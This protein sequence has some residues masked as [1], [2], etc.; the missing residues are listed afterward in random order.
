MTA[1]QL[2]I[3]GVFSPNEGEEGQ[4]VEFAVLEWK[5]LPQRDGPTASDELPHIRIHTFVTPRVP[6]ECAGE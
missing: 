6:A 2:C 4:T 5:V 3:A 1:R